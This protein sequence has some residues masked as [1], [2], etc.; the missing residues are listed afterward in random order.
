MKTSFVSIALAAA[1]AVAGFAPA[2]IAAPQKLISTCPSGTKAF[3]KSPGVNSNWSADKPCCNT[4]STEGLYSLC[5]ARVP[6]R[7][8]SQP[9]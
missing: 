9:R 1:F 2:A 5:Q 8:K 7:S 3:S 4:T 6:V